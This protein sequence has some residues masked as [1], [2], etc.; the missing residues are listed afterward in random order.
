LPIY[1]AAGVI[2][3]AVIAGVI[4]FKFFPGDDGY[5]PPETYED[6]PNVFDD[7]DDDGNGDDDDDDDGDESSDYELPPPDTPVSKRTR[8]G[9]D[10]DENSVNYYESPTSFA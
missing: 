2:V 10:R 4:Y 3:V 8:Y 7:D 6:G 5:Q 1:T 9:G